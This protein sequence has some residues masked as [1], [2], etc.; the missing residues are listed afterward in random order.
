MLGDEALI[1]RTS[2]R[3]RAGDECTAEDESTLRLFSF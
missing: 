1:L 2:H 3:F